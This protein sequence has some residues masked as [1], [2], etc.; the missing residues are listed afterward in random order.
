MIKYFNQIYIYVYMTN[1][2][3]YTSRHVNT[4]A[5]VATSPATRITAVDDKAD[6]WWWDGEMMSWWDELMTI[7]DWWCAMVTTKK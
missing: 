7:T 2:Y 3:W 6:A 4:V 5:P 1:K